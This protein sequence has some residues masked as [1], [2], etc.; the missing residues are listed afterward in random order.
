MKQMNQSIY[1]IDRV[2]LTDSQKSIE[3]LFFFPFRN[4][5]YEHITFVEVRILEFKLVFPM[6]PKVTEK[7]MCALK[8]H[9][10]VYI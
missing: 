8:T 9:T 10:S 7:C 6:S 3:S 4:V 2:C 1:C 5:S